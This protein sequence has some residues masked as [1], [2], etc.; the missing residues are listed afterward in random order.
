M[1]AIFSR[2]FSYES[3]LGFASELVDFGGLLDEVSLGARG[4]RVGSVGGGFD[5]L[6][7]MLG[8]GHGEAGLPNNMTV[9]SLGLV[10]ERDVSMGV[11]G[12]YEQRGCGV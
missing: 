12:R 2:V 1:S 6:G 8:D 11:G 5:R 9:W 10:S 3:C 7:V 4:G